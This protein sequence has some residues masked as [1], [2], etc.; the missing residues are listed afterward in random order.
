MHAIKALL[1]DLGNVLI[2]WEPRQLYRK[3]FGGDHAAMEYFLE[4]ICSSEWNRRIDAGLPFA[5]A[6]AE[7]QQR[8]PDHAGP[9]AAWQQRWPEML[10]GPIEGT[11]A[12]LRET[13]AAGYRVCA[14]S[15]WSA[16]TF[17]IA[18]MRFE[19]LQWFERIVVSGEVGLAKP[20][21]AIF[22]LAL[23]ECA[24]EPSTTLFIDD[25]PENVATARTL[26]LQAIRFEHPG[27][28]RT[29]LARLGVLGAR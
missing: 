19:F 23:R 5:H 3:I 27:Q 6:V 28:L 24:L 12:I 26:G 4:H 10:G 8:H 15:N 18:R 7:L 11:V 9:I 20:D 21:P 29:E 1:F 2:E 25:V 22:E 17:P 14:L 13:R 16:E